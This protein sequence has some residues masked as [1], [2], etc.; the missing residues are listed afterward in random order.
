MTTTGPRLRLGPPHDGA[1]TMA[2]KLLTLGSTW[3]WS[4]F[5]KSEMACRHCGHL[6]VDPAL[7]DALEWLRA[8]CG[9]PLL[10]TSGYRCTEHPAEATKTG[11]PGAH[12]HGWAADVAVHGRGAFSL[13]E[14][15]GV[16]NAGLV[17]GAR[18]V[19]GLGVAWS[20]IHLDVAPVGWRSARPYLWTYER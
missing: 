9:F 13:V 15:I 14:A 16:Y 18:P 6:L 17:S 7:M 11:L 20:Y 3:A 8:R 10:V 1:L 19:T 5:S 12:T 2:E 4:R